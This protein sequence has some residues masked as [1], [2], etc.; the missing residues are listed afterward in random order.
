MS[1]A[2]QTGGREPGPAPPSPSL[3]DF[4]DAT[5]GPAERAWA[6]AIVDGMS[7]PVVLVSACDPRRPSAWRLTVHPRL[8]AMRSASLRAPEVAAWLCDRPERGVIQIVH[9]LP[10]DTPIVEIPAPS[11]G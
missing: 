9:F 7:D 2:T 10:G 5:R 4:I 6:E 3:A 1:R 8:A 11:G